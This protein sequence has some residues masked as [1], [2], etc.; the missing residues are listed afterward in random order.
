MHPQ[1]FANWMKIHNNTVFKLHKTVK[2]N[3]GDYGYVFNYDIKDKTS[4]LV[5]WVKFPRTN[6]VECYDIEG[7]GLNHSKIELCKTQ[8]KTPNNPKFI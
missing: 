2:K 1:D 6:I 8:R 3:Y 4:G 5:I 7:K